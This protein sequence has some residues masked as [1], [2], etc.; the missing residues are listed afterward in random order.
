MVN[1]VYRA[2]PAACFSFVFLTFCVYSM[3]DCTLLLPVL[4]MTLEE[5]LIL[6]DDYYF[7]L[8]NS[9]C[10]A[11]LNVNAVFSPE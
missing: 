6:N 8:S 5:M 4:A 2:P 3:C 11:F 9:S 7:Q 10:L 1:Y